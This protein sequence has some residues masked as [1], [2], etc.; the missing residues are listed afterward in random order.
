M[1]KLYL[2]Y[3][4]IAQC[5]FLNIMPKMCFNITINKNCMISV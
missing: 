2:E 5:R 3:F 1:I 4:F